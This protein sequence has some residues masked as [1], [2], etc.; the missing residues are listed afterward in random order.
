MYVV[1]RPPPTRSFFETTMPASS[2]PQRRLMAMALRY[3]RGELA[4]PSAEVKT[5]AAGMTSDKLREFAKKPSHHE[6]VFK[7]HKGV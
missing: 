2:E 6:T 7:H 3:K 4:A 5:V 1:L